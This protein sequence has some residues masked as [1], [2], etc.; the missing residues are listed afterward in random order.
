M[1]MGLSNDPEVQYRAELL[2]HFM[3]RKIPNSI[4]DDENPDNDLFGRKRESTKYEETKRASLKQSMATSPTSAHT[5]VASVTRENDDESKKC[6]GTRCANCKPFGGNNSSEDLN[7]VEAEELEVQNIESDAFASGTA[8]KS[9][10]RRARIVATDSAGSSHKALPA[11]ARQWD[12]RE[13]F[14]GDAYLFQ[15]YGLSKIDSVAAYDCVI[16]SGCSSS[17]DL[18]SY[19]NQNKLARLQGVCNCSTSDQERGPHDITCGSRVA[20]MWA[21]GLTNINIPAFH[22]VKIIEALQK[23]LK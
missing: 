9:S 5:D 3:L 14:C 21:G 19:L 15:S 18:L 16:R 13:M 12:L 22:A 20:A 8:S 17:E 7:E 4:V 10:H 23:D 6:G 1:H 2:S 11:S